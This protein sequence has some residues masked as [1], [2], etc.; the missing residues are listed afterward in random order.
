M[1]STSSGCVGRHRAC[2][3]AVSKERPGIKVRAEYGIPS[4]DRNATASTGSMARTFVSPTKCA[5]FWAELPSMMGASLRSA[6]LSCSPP[7][8]APFHIE[9]NETT[10]TVDWK[11]RYRIEGD[12]FVYMDRETGRLA[13]IHGYPTLAA[14]LPHPFAPPP[15]ALSFDLPPLAKT[16][17]AA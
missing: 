11:G 1:I 4:A 8:Q 9:E 13:T 10:F 15:L 2:A 6:R 17:P 16:E 12:A 7:R 14:S 5:T 3:P